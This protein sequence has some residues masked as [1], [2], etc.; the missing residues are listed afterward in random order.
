MPDIDPE[1]E[2]LVMEAVNRGGDNR[3]VKALTAILRRG[4]ITT[5]ELKELDYD[6]PPRAASDIKDLGIPLISERVKSRSGKS[7]ARYRFGTAEQIRVGQA[8]RSSFSKKFRK[9][10]FDAY[11]AVD[12]ITRAPHDPRSLQIDHRIPFRVGGDSGLET[13]DVSA[14]ML[15]D[16]QSQRAKSWSCENCRN[17]IEL[18]DPA[19]CRTCFWAYPERYDH[20][21]MTDIRRADI[22]W[23]GSEI[24]DYGR[25]VEAA[26]RSGMSIQD[27]LKALGRA[28]K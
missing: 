9:A 20:V 13:N 5:E 22:V 15:L 21:A 12:C 7:I 2:K 10:L 23:Q 1:V 3:V 24:P 17:F 16:A 28:Q 14:F 8:K 6:H 27:Y 11:G 4:G 26:A 18:R 25:I 19:I